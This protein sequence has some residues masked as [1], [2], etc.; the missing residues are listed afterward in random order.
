MNAGKVWFGISLLALLC[1]FAIPARAETEA[2][3]KQAAKEHY[4]IATRFYD[5][6]KYGEAIQEYEAA[7]LLF[8]DPNLLYNIGQ[9]YR[10][11]DK[12]EEAI[13]SYKN[14][15]RH[16]PDAPNRA[17]VE[18]RI[19][20]LE[21]T[22]DEH[23]PSATELPAAAPGGKTNPEPTP[24]GPPGASPAPAAPPAPGAA[25]VAQAAAPQKPAGPSWLDTH[26]RT[27]AYVLFS[28][29]G[30]C[31]VTSMVTG[32]LAISKAKQLADDSKKPNHPVFD[33]S[34][35][36]SGKT[37][38]TVAI[39]TGVTGLALGGAG[40]YLFFRS[41]RAADTAS[42]EPAKPFALFPLAG[43]GLAGVGA[44]MDF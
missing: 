32:L 23:R 38:N 34:L 4:E 25:A 31:L 12:P 3:K 36:S 42:A 26:S 33:P 43:P 27:G 17:D 40:L 30:A 6:G 15:L 7:Y 22:G 10:L 9:A 24:A 5:L 16:R 19:S 2:Q 21:R 13:R 28:A 11:W 14:Y 20:E 18:K 8:A 44:S 1:S 39:V 35:Q 29:G 41:R 37:L